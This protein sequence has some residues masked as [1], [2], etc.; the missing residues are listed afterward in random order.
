MQGNHIVALGK[1]KG[2]VKRWMY[3]RTI[4]NQVSK[5]FKKCMIPVNRL[6]DCGLPII[7]GLRYSQVPSERTLLCRCR[8]S[9]LMFPRKHD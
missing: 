8:K 3:L 6:H 2:M 4:L 9:C 5:H 1:L 7:G